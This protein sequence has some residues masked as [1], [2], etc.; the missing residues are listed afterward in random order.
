MSRSEI[1]IDLGA[2]RRNVAV[3]AE[4]AGG[5]E[6]WGVVKADAYGHGATE[7]ARALEEEGARWLGVTS[8]DEAIPLRDLTVR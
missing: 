2:L 4:A 3:L 5:A 7:C 6:L 1:T 8:L